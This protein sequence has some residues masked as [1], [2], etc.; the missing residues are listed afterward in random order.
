MA[1]YKMIAGEAARLAEAILSFLHDRLD[2]AAH[3]AQI[4]DAPLVVHDPE[5]DDLQPRRRAVLL[6]MLQQFL[7]LIHSSASSSSVS[8]ISPSGA[9][10][11]SS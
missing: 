5:V 6:E 10:F 7:R 3:L 11:A 9:P 2:G 4:V 1:F 8:P